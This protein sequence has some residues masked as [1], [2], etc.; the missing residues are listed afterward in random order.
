MVYNMEHN[1]VHS[2]QKNTVEVQVFFVMYACTKSLQK[3]HRKLCTKI[4]NSLSPVY[5]HAY[6]LIFKLTK[7]NLN[8]IEFFISYFLPII[9]FLLL[10][11]YGDTEANP[12]PKKKEQTYFSL[13]HWNVNSLV[14][15][16]KNIFNSCCI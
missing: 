13:C 7:L 9:L 11:L 4:S 6:A 3:V 5:G 15:H 10:L 1:M 14:A 16:E 2:L 8:N 12:R